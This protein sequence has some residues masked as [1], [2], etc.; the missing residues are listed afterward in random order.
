MTAIYPTANTLLLIIFVV[1]IN[2]IFG[3]YRDETTVRDVFIGYLI[4]RV[5]DKPPLVF[6]GGL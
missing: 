3:C 2:F 4:F 1:K 5:K 6:M